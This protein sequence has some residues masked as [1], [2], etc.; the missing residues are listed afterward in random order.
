MMYL[1]IAFIPSLVE[2]LAFHWITGS[3]L[4]DSVADKTYDVSC[5]E[6]KRCG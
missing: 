2:P 1:S 6:T 5:P 4:R 3:P